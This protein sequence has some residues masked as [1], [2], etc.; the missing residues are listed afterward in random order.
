MSTRNPVETL[1]SDHQRWLVSW[2]H[3]RT[4]CSQQA[5]D[6]AQDTFLRVLLAEHRQPVAATLSEPRHF[7]VTI[8][9]RVMIDSFRRQSVE[10]AYLEVLARQPESFEL[11]AEERLIILQTLQALDRMLDGLGRRAKAAF[12][13]SQLQGLTYPQ[14]AEQLQISVSSVTKYMARATEHCLLF[15][16]DNPL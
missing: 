3:K 15:V 13:M 1:Y 6:F 2:L 11:S 9:K 8:A 14:I 12:L 5:A 4:G 10:R 16:M 7:L